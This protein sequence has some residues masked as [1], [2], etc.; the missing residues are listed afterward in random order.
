MLTSKKLNPGLSLLTALGLG[1]LGQSA[2]A[3]D[4]VFVYGTSQA[5]QAETTAAELRAEM[6]RYARSLHLELKRK[7]DQAMKPADKPKLELSEVELP[8][9]ELLTR[10]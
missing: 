3:T 10:S 8:A 6:D 2:A 1:L 7:L 5:A 9:R 4:E